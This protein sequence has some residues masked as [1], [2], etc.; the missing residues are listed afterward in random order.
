MSEWLGL[1][2]YGVL[3]LLMLGYPLALWWGRRTA[4]QPQ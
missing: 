2:T 1:L 4:I 3:G